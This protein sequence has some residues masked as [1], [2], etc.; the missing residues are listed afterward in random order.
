MLQWYCFKALEIKLISSVLAT[1]S[2]LRLVPTSLLSELNPKCGCK[3]LLQTESSKENNSIID[4]ERLAEKD[5]H[6]AKK[7]LSPLECLPVRC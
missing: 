4:D 6:L 2:K 7:Q 5:E 1:P 3:T